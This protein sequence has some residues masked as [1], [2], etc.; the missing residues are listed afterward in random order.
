MLTSLASILGGAPIRF[1]PLQ[2]AE[3]TWVSLGIFHPRKSGV[4]GIAGDFGPSL[5]GYRKLSF[6]KRG[7]EIALHQGSSS[8]FQWTA[9]EHKKGFLATCSFQ[10]QAVDFF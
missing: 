3:Y 7:G 2:M 1:K 8:N 4:T 5:K 6:V 9:S 10:L